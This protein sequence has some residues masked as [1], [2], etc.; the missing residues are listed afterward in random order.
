ME[1]FLII[2]AALIGYLAGSIS[3]ARIVTRLAAPQADLS[4]LRIQVEGSDE[5]VD[6]G[7]MGANAASMVLGPKL[8]LL[9]ALLD[10]AKVAVP[11]LVFRWIFPLQ[12]YHLVVAIAGLVGHNWPVYYRFKGGRGF[13][14]ILASFLVV[15][16]VG[17][18]IVILGGLAFGMLI[19]GNTM[20]AYISWLW[21][22]IPWIVWKGDQ[23]EI[24]FVIL[25][26]I[27]FVLATIPEIRVILRMRKSGK[28]A[29]YT[30]GLY[31][32]SPRWRGMYKMTQKLWLLR[33]FLRK[34]VRD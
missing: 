16:W 8:G 6:V 5:S 19:L 21:W 23:W 30:Q 27:I 7:I 34:D 31:N 2:L 24:I 3:F 9:V 4:Q 29:E 28:L 17:T 20:I 1:P 14:V 12:P 18:L 13:A 15:D 25:I 26:N 32:S 10:M 22:M 11:M 33:P